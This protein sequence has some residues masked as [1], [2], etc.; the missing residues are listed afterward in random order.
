MLRWKKYAII[1]S[2]FCFMTFPVRLTKSCGPGTPGFYGYSFLKPKLVK[3]TTT[4]A[5]FLLN[6]EDIYKK[7]KAEHQARQ[8][9][10]NIKE[11]QERFCKLAA[12]KDIESVVYNWSIEDLQ[13]VRS[14]AQSEKTD[15]PARLKRNTFADHLNKNRCYE[16]IDYLIFAKKCEPFVTINGKYWETNTPDTLAMQNLISERKKDFKSLKSHYI[17]LRYAY[18]MIRLAHYA[19]EY[20]QV[21]ELHEY[22]MPKV[23]AHESII[24][25]WIMGHRAGA[26]LSLGKRVE[27]AY[28]YSLIF[29]NC[30][31]KR[32]SAIQSFSIKTEEEWKQCMLQCKSDEERAIIFT[33]RASKEESRAAEEMEHIYELDPNNENLDLLLVKEIQK[34]EKDLLGNDFKPNQDLRWNKKYHDIPRAEAG[35]YAIRLE[36]L[37]HEV[38]EDNQIE[39]IDLWKVADGYLEMLRGDFYAAEKTFT[40]YEKEITKPAL[41]NQ[42]KALQLALKINAYEDLDNEDEMEIADMI[43]NNETYNSFRDFPKF[44]FDKLAYAYQ[45]S[46]E[47]GKA[48]LSRFTINDLRTNPKTE[49][50]DNLLDIAKKEDKNRLERKFLAGE[51]GQEDSIRYELLDMRGSHLMGENQME[52]ALEVFKEIPRTVRERYRLNPFRDKLKDCV[53]CPSKDTLVYDKVTLIEELIRLDYEG[54][55]SLEKGA[56]FFYRLGIAHYNMTY[57]GN[58]WQAKDYYRSGYNWMYENDENT[59]PLY[60]TP[61]GNREYK[62]CSLAQY[63][64]EK[65]RLMSKDKEAA[66][67]AAYMG[68]K[69]EQNT[70]FGSKS[71]N[72]SPY[73]NSIPN[74]PDKHRT[75]FKML[76]EDYNDTEFYKKI[77]KE[78]KYFRA[79][80]L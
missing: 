29:K 52:A 3:A 24:Y 10:D 63:Y 23:D 36:K 80:T 79:Y 51:D 20:E 47:V 8:T 69:C 62:D 42:I 59:Y 35:K 6:I 49:I 73:S 27:A 30:P 11:W 7:A 40:K 46:D 55:A 78:C 18:Q 12:I 5:P 45:E 33:M 65:A 9:S 17:K 72:Y 71:C 34:L 37:V 56:P 53:H 19:N 70:W 67:R 21:L 48:F 76:K 60:G 38:V 77:I 74:V 32:I 4:Y 1:L 58:T 16:T 75:Y 68:A 57:F 31:S 15:L 25:Y 43:R 28:L 44:L 22:L 54:K 2:S 39:N 66:A 14:A 13:V 61:Y 64:F 26:L 41:A 50:V